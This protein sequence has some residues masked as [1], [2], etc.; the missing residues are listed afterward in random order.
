LFVA[1]IVL[2]SAYR[3]GQTTGDAFGVYTVGTCVSLFLVCVTFA[4]KRNS[5]RS[6]VTIIILMATGMVFLLA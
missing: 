3:E 2:A 1:A 5:R 6:V 4:A